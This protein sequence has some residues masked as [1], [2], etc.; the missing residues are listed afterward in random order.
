MKLKVK[1]ARRAVDVPLTK[2]IRSAKTA[3]YTDEG[4]CM[5]DCTAVKDPE[6]LALGLSS[7]HELGA[8]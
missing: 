5:R 6:V 3:A 2:V 7:Q 1:T 8:Q 4:A